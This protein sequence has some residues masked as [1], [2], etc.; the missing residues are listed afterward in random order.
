[1][2]KTKPVK[3]VTKPLPEDYDS[4]EEYY[5]N[6]WLNELYRSD[7][8]RVFGKHRSTYKL[9]EK[10]QVFFAGKRKEASKTIIKEIKYTPD[11]H[12]ML[13]G[14]T[15]FIFPYYNK[16]N[17]NQETDYL[18]PGIYADSNNNVIYF[19][20]KG[21]YTKHLNSSITFKDRQAMLFKSQGIFVN[22]VIPYSLNNKYKNTLFEQTFCPQ[23]FIDD[24]VY[25]KGEKK[26]QSKIPF[27]IKTFS[28]FY[29]E[30]QEKLKKY[31]EQQQQNTE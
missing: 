22:K 30:Y 23:K 25:V 19:E 16:K 12:S 4:W 17:K 21:A 13:Y 28:Q 6:E 26:G 9:C 10:V 1:M 3:T 24:M 29:D 2:I 8:I 11:F 18:I 15:P 20:V 31:N 5:F 27:T 14:S 7:I